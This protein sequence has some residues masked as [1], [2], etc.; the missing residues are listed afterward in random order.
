ML[1]Q[2]GKSG[3]KCF[4]HV[5]ALR[6]CAICALLSL[7]SLHGHPAGDESVTTHD[8]RSTGAQECVTTFYYA[9][10]R[11]VPRLLSRWPQHHTIALIVTPR[12]VTV[13][14][15]CGRGLRGMFGCCVLNRVSFV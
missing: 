4:K 8:E 9:A 7:L 2:L 13:K 5:L 1:Y 15:C 6:K 10:S 12:G 3:E 11:F 14:W